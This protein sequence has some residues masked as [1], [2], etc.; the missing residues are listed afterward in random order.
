[1]N[2]KRLAWF[3]APLV[4]VLAGCS[5]DASGGDGQGDGDALEGT[6]NVRA[7]LS[8]A[9][10][11]SLRGETELGCGLPHSI[12]DG[13]RTLLLLPAGVDGPIG[14][15]DL[16]ID[17]VK[18]GETGEF[19]AQVTIHMNDDGPRYTST[20]CRVTITENAFVENRTDP[21]QTR[22]YLVRGTGTCSAPL[23]DQAGAEVVLSPFQFV[24]SSVWQ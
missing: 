10:T 23:V 20:A 7:E 18:E 12:D 21:V 8:G 4:V 2:R 14:S 24:T 3:F 17:A 22:D 13:I 9:V 15:F 19:D 6:C 5:D 11:E 16:D 1:M